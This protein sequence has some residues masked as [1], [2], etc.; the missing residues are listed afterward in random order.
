VKCV[1][2]PQKQDF[3]T[4]AIYADPDGLPFSV[5]EEELLQQPAP[6]PGWPTPHDLL[7]RYISL[8][9]SPQ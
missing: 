3:G 2:P 7:M 1:Q 4:L 9:I 5:V 6:F 8:P